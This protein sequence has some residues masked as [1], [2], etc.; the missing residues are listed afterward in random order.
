MGLVSFYCCRID[1][2]RWG[3]RTGGDA[4]A[5]D[6][7]AVTAGTAT[8][9][10]AA[11][12]ASQAG[13]GPGLPLVAD[14]SMLGSMALVQLPAPSSFSLSSGYSATTN[15]DATSSDAKVHRIKR[16]VN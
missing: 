2:E 14:D 4:P 16:I 7:V 13:H 11:A 5:D 10:A 15:S 3:E 1:R 12:A 6:G 9:A 8:S